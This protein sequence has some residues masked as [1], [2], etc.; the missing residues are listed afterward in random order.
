[1]TVASVTTDINIG[2]FKI[3]S[4]AQNMIMNNYADRNKISIELVIPEP[5]MS[6]SLATLQW[7]HNDRKLSL[8][9]LSSIYQL[10]DE[11]NNISKIINNMS[12]VN[13][14]FAIE[15]LNGKGKDFLNKC[16]E[17]AKKFMKITVIDS[18]K[19]KWSELYEMKKNLI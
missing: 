7:I 4:N 18:T 6:R 14:H 8:V 19:T 3:P 10:P 12:E 1:M 16:I 2:P 9:I 17:E 15:G 13:F 5:M 11:V